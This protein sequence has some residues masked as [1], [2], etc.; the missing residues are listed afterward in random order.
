M[1]I[2]KS[3]NTCEPY[4]PDQDVATPVYYLQVSRMIS[5]VI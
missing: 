5:P 1:L 4:I 3:Q 2:K